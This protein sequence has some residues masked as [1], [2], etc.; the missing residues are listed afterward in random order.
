MNSYAEDDEDARQQARW[1]HHLQQASLG[2]KLTIGTR[3]GSEVAFFNWL[4]GEAFTTY[5]TQ[6][7]DYA[8]KRIIFPNGGS[9]CVVSEIEAARLEKTGGLTIVDRI[10]SREDEE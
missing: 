4:A 5:L 7:I 9:V 8:G 2:W 1:L 10:S 6:Q 3:G